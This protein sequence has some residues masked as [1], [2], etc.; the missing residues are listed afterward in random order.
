MTLETIPARPTPGGLVRLSRNPILTLAAAMCL[1]LAASAAQAQN[2]DLR[3]QLFSSVESPP[4]GET[5]TYTIIVDNLGPDTAQNIII[6]DT[7]VTSDAVDPNGCSIAVRTQGGAIDEFTC[8]FA[9]STGVFD[10]GEFGSN[11]LNPRGQVYTDP[12]QP[13][14]TDCRDK[15]RIIV[16]VNL[17]AQEGATLQS[18]ADVDS[19]TNDPD[20]SNNVATTITTFEA[21]ADLGV[22]Q[23]SSTP[24]PDAGEMVE[25][26]YTVENHGPSA[27]EN[28]IL[29]SSLPEGVV[30]GSVAIT[31]NTVEDIAGS[32]VVH[33]PVSCTMGTPGMP[34]D[35]SR[36]DLGG[37]PVGWGAELT[38]SARIDPAYIAD[39]GVGPP[40]G[41]RNDVRVSSDTLDANFESNPD[42]DCAGGT[43]PCPPAPDEANFS[44]LTVDVGESADL[45][46]SKF[47]VG[48]ATVGEDMH[49]EFD[50][51]NAGPSVARDVTLRDFLPDGLEFVDAVVDREG[52][53]GFQ[54]LSC[55]VTEGSNALFC[56]LGDVPVND[57]G[58]P[59]L[60]FATVRIDTSVPNGAILTNNAD[61]L[62]TDTP[63][64][65]SG[66]SSDS[67]S[68]TVNNPFDIDY[69][70]EVFG[71]GGIDLEGR[72]I[73]LRPSS[74][75]DMYTACIRHAEVPP[76]TSGTA[77][78]LDDDDS[79]EVQLS[80]GKKIRFYGRKYDRLYISSNGYVTLGQADTEYLPSPETHFAVKRI[81]PFFADLDP[82][83]AGEIWWRQTTDRVVIA[84]DGVPGYKVADTNTVY[85]ELFFS[86]EI[87]MRYAS[88]DALAS[89]VGFS[90]GMGVPDPFHPSDFDGAG[91]YPACSTVTA[92]IFTD[93]FRGF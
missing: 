71:A 91:Q 27:A 92:R 83:E 80:G 81:A 21:V 43:Q 16:T 49:Y 85:L 38:L 73:E 37:L 5:F 84:W 65:D 42:D 40:V 77:L 10:L 28:A 87:F 19:E 3:I 44:S 89:V 23:T 33:A 82:R 2:A 47:A 25:W 66:N 6:R 26:T 67:A 36:C 79:V 69:F 70:T 8:N 64:P 41:L 24:T 56:P 11:H 18:T 22:T 93:D 59:I 20:T 34:S 32:A 51:N 63:D 62:L 17:S 30:E 78:S 68:M 4:A 60:V 9:L 57:S 48:P 61:V 52:A 31:G 74:N 1:L 54:P 12:A 75:D 35:P 13:C 14:N 58:A 55:F 88:L 53:A 15:G 50:V 90:R 39:A 46:L 7:L 72:Q 45:S 86:G 29:Q 76:V